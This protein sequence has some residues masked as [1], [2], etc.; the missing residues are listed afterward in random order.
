MKCPNCGEA[1]ESP[2][3]FCG[4]CGTP[5]EY[6]KKGTHWVP[7]LILLGVSLLGLAL[8]FIFPTASAPAA[9]W[10]TVRDGAL[11]F[12]EA[13]YQGGPQV[14][15]PAFID[16]QTVSAIGRHGFSDC[17]T[18]TSLVLPDTVTAIGDYAFSSCNALRAV[19]LPESVTVIG[20]GAFVWCSS[21]EAVHI[22]AGVEQIGETAF[23][24][25]DSLAYI[26]F[27]GTA[28][29]WESLYPWSIESHPMICT[30]DGNRFR[31]E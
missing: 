29:E 3:R 17:D 5:L 22:P 6:E 16:G 12:D 13:S 8:Y 14:E 21:L 2:H 1:Y 25:C 18:I 24:G 31:S 7:L 28:D 9:P 26:F 30:P 10:F 20:A 27:D 11:V 19:D 4:Q 23:S 15:V